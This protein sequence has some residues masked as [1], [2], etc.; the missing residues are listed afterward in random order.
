MVH[1]DRVTD[2]HD[3]FIAFEPSKGIAPPAVPLSGHCLAKS[4]H[5]RANDRDAT[6]RTLRARDPLG[7]SVTYEAMDTRQDWKQVTRSRVTGINEDQD[8]GIV[9]DPEQ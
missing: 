4:Q 8:E 5:A 1:V 9:G 6:N 7:Q 3:W 2:S